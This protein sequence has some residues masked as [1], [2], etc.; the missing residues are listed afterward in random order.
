MESKYKEKVGRTRQDRTW[1]EGEERRRGP[2]SLRDS[3]PTSPLMAAHPWSRAPGSGRYR[4]TSWPEPTVGTGALREACLLTL[5]R[6][7]CR[8]SQQLAEELGSQGARVCP[9][10]RLWPPGPCQVKW[11]HLAAPQGPEGFWVEGPQ[12]AC[13]PGTHVTGHCPGL[14]LTSPLQSDWVVSHHALRPSATMWSPFN[15]F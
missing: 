7:S 8:P 5:S 14:T 10:R 1:E 15:V 6:G 4:A 12:V 9:R 2:S 3:W 11:G 13:F